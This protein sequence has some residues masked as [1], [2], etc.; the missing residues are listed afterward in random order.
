M[1]YFLMIFAVAAIVLFIVVDTSQNYLTSLLLKALASFGFVG[2]YISVLF[3]KVVKI[4]S[5]FYLGASFT[6][7]VS[8]ALLLGLGL[9]AG[10][11]GDMVLGLRPLLPKEKNFTLIIAGMIAFSVGQMLVYLSLLSLQRFSFYPILFSLVVSTIVFLAA[12]A[13]KIEWGKAKTPAIIYS[14]LIF[15]MIGQAIMNAIWMDFSAY[16]VIFLTGALLFAISDLV[17]SQIYFKA[18]FSKKLVVVNL[19][20]Y[21]SAQL[22]FALSV[23]FIR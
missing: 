23:L 13:M 12:K 7:Y 3:E 15:L 9:V 5:N 2:V 18:S 8:F 11:I 14:F 22:L 10:L 4:D 16:S 21:Y 19:G 1:I 6:L 20:T 17:L